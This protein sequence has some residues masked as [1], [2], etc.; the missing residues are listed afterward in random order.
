ML[1]ISFTFDYYNYVYI[2]FFKNKVNISAKESDMLLQSNWS[3]HI[4]IGIYKKQNVIIDNMLLLIQAVLAI[5][6][7]HE[8]LINVKTLSTFMILSYGDKLNL[9]TY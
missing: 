2:L 5:G 9:Y 3:I 1:Y 7:V 4:K 8:T 6:N